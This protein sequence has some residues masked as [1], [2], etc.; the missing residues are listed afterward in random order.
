VLVV[1]DEE[2]VRHM[3]ARALTDAGFRASEARDGEEARGLLDTAG[4]QIGLVV[5][6]MTMPGMTGLVARVVAELRPGL[7]VLLVSGAEVPPEPY[8]G[9]FLPKPFLP[10][11]LVQ[12][13]TGFLPF[14]ESTRAS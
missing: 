11:A 8:L 1:N 3:M 5:S 9:A 7:P 10:E 13:V 4:Q 6:D 12:A 2:A 14:S